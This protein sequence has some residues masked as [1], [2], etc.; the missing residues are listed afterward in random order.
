MKFL[1]ILPILFIV[2]RISFAA[3]WELEKGSTGIGGSFTYNSKSG[4]LYE[5]SRGEGHTIATLATNYQYFFSTMFSMGGN[6]MFS[7]FS[8]GNYTSRTVSIGPAV[9]YYFGDRTSKNWPFIG[10]SFLAETVSWDDD[11]WN[12]NNSYKNTTIQMS[13]GMMF[14]LVDHYGIRGGLFYNI[15][16][17][18]FDNEAEKGNVFGLRFGFSGFI[19]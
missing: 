17:S 14:K 9:T 18:E 3:D 13:A 8:R 5:D 6:F 19:Y 2:S 10:A 7:S 15:D 11:S 12:E 4:D 16:Q 1:C